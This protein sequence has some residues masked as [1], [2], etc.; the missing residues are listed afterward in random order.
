M[1]LQL[2]ANVSHR[3]VQSTIKMTSLQAMHK[4]VNSR[5]LFIRI[6]CHFTVDTRIIKRITRQCFTLLACQLR[7]SLTLFE[8]LPNQL[9]SQIHN[10]EI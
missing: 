7:V 10:T 4:N 3:R 5:Y 9:A 1:L 6:C 8:N 2:T